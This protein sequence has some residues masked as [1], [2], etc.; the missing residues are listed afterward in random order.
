[1]RRLRD[2]GWLVALWI[3]GCTMD[4]SAGHG[5]GDTASPKGDAYLGEVPGIPPCRAHSDC[6]HGDLCIAAYLL[7]DDVVDVLRVRGYFV[8]GVA[9]D[10][11]I[12]R[13]AHPRDYRIQRVDLEV[14]TERGFW[15]R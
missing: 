7:P 4:A 5:A 15:D 9:F 11:G 6:A 3:T 12:C 1:M 8:E 14:L 13:S 2:G 10:G